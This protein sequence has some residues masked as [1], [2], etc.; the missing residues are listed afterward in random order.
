MTF[1]PGIPLSMPLTFHR[2]FI[3]FRELVAGRPR[4][5]SGRG[6][7]PVVPINKLQGTESEKQATQTL[8]IL[9]YFAVFVTIFICCCF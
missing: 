5:A 2:R 1:A 3:S 9:M 6:A 4:G 7:V 8:H